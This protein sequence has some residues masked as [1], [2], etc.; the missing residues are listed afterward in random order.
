MAK[1]LTLEQR[2]IR[3]VNWSRLLLVLITG[4][5][6]APFILSAIGGIVGMAIAGA[7]GV[8]LLASAKP[9][10]MVV[11]NLRMKA[12]KDIAKSSPMEVI[13]NGVKDKETKV[14][15]FEQGLRTYKASLEML[16]TSYERTWSKYPERKPELERRLG[17]R[18]DRYNGNV[19]KLR[20]AK[21]ELLSSIE[22]MEEYRHM[23]QLAEDEAKINQLEGTF[24]GSVEDNI[25]M[26]TAF[27]EIRRRDAESSAV[28]DDLDNDILEMANAE[29]IR[30]EHQPTDTIDETVAKLKAGV[31]RP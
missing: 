23:L 22:R 10:G 19:Q 11:A 17:E 5:L 21:Q 24:K 9:F 3:I 14:R 7:V 31:V 30:I 4:F 1:T 2:K 8:I 25:A 15:Q 12:I 18:F 20:T 6:V 27:E 16:K 26:N 29:P 28:F 13:E